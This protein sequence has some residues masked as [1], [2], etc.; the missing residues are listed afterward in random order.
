M[1][2]SHFGLFPD[3]ME[4]QA[5]ITSYDIFLP[6]TRVSLNEYLD[7]L[8]YRKSGPIVGHIMT[9]HHRDTTEM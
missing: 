4:K 8:V 5:P 1:I 2:I 6:D 7:L 9:P 3:I